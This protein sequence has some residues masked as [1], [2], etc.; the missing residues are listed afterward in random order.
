MANGN[1]LTADEW[2]KLANAAGLGHADA[3]ELSEFYNNTLTRL[4]TL[5][6]GLPAVSLGYYDVR[7]H[8]LVADGVTDNRAALRTLINTAIAAGGGT[9]YFPAGVWHV[10]IGGAGDRTSIPLIAK[11]N[12]KLRI[13]GDGPEATVITWG[14]DAGGGDAHLFNLENGSSGLVVENIKFMQKDALTNPDPA[15]QHHAFRI[16]ARNTEHCER[17]VFRNVHFGV[18]KGDGLFM[19]GASTVQECRGAFA[20]TIAAG[21]VPGPFTNPTTPKRLAVVFPASWDGGDITITGTDVQNQTISETFPALSGDTWVGYEY[22]KT[23]TGVTKSA[24]G[25]QNVSATIGFV[26]EVRDVLV[27]GCKFNGFDYAGSAPGYGYRACIVGQR[28]TNNVRIVNSTFTGSSDQLIDF[29]PT[30]DGNL[31]AWHIDRCWFRA[32]NPNPTAR[33]PTAITIGGNG[34]TNPPPNTLENSTF[35][36]NVIWGRVKV[37]NGLT[38]CKFL[39]NQI[40]IDTNEVSSEGAFTFTGTMIDC[41]IAGNTITTRSTF[42]RNCL[43]VIN[44][45]G[46]RATGL[47]IRDNVIRYYAGVGMKVENVQHAEIYGN[48]LYYL[49][50]ATGTDYGIECGNTTIAVNNLSIHDNVIVGDAGGGSLIRGIRIG[51]GSTAETT[52]LSICNNRGSGF[53]NGIVVSAPTGSAS[54]STFPIIAGNDM[55][56]SVGT[57][58]I[59]ATAGNVG[60][61]R[62]LRSSTADPATVAALD[63]EELGTLY[64]GGNGTVYRKSGAGAAWTAM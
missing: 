1:S 39:N 62:M 64:S 41:E 36:N 9:I 10:G 38:R 48:R 32:A 12:M 40:T 6:T 34:D 23:V 25:V 3:V 54:F 61:W 35:S 15:E 57:G 28:L 49:A 26:Y 59:Y 16:A 8:G 46:N 45:S 4:T 7:G 58:V 20:A 42:T 47:T 44:D 2:L 14:G 53:T 17:F 31:Q 50:S 33:V 56:L 21:A 11:G 51:P 63:N 19:V 43:V 18:F 29:E 5:E 24:T 60:T 13:V 37:A 30:G 55:S 27:D 22:F 52:R